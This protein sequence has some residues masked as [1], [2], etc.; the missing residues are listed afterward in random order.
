MTGEPESD[1]EQRSRRRAALL[2]ASAGLRSQ[3]PIAVLIHS[4]RD[5][6]IQLDRQDMDR[7]LCDSRAER[8]A[9]AAAVG[10]LIVDKLPFVPA[11]TK[12][13]PFAGRLIFGGLAGYLGASSSNG[14]SRSGALAGAAAAGVTATAGTTLRATLPRVTGYPKFAVAIAEDVLAFVVATYAI[15]TDR[16]GKR[17]HLNTDDAHPL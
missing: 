10:E 1:K 5:G 16:P 4:S 17:E 15:R 14:S 12:P 8:I 11:R 2:G 13:G 7:W 9:M 3:A 6:R